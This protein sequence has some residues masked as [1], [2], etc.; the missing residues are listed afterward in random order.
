MPTNPPSDSTTNNRWFTLVA[1]P[2]WR[3]RA[4]LREFLDQFLNKL[5]SPDPLQLILWLP[6]E[7][8]HRI[9]ATSKTVTTL[10]GSVV[11]NTIGPRNVSLLSDLSITNSRDVLQSAETDVFIS[12]GNQADIALEREA[13]ARGLRVSSPNAREMSRSIDCRRDRES[14]EERIPVLKL[15]SSQQAAGHPESSQVHSLVDLFADG[16]RHFLA[17]DETQFQ[18][19]VAMR[20]LF[21]LTNGSFNRAIQEITASIYPAYEMST[22]EGILSKSH[23]PESIFDDLHQFGFAVIERRLPNDQVAKLRAL[24]TKTPCKRYAPAGEPKVFDPNNPTA[25]RYRMPEKELISTPE[26]QALLC[27]PSILSMAQKVLGSQPILSHVEMWWTTDINEHPDSTTAQLF[28]FD[29]DKL[30]MVHLFIYLCD[31]DTN[32]GPHTYVPGSHLH[33]PLPLRRDGRISDK[34]I[35]HHFGEDGIVEI[36]GPA[37]TMIIERTRGF[38]KGKRVHAGNRLLMEIVFSGS[39]FGA[40]YERMPLPK[41]L[42]QPFKRALNNYP[43]VFSRYTSS[44]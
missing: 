42:T 19:Y 4:I 2:D 1:L 36:C 20:R 13:V 33:K 38:H 24:A 14:F 9:E 8:S 40:P 21:Y 28:H 25:V 3:N 12:F 22:T 30:E 6:P 43:R 10:I 16:Y 17:S 5:Q 39:L 31:V 32:T 34:E 7:F 26:I 35:T 29:A 41:A 11:K 15:E 44:E 37:G 18:A 23:N 27:D